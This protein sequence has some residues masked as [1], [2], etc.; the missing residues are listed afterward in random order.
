MGQLEL[1][2]DQ[3]QCGY[4]HKRQGSEHERHLQVTHLLLELEDAVAAP[5]ERRSGEST[6]A[7][8]LTVALGHRR[9]R[10]LLDGGVG[11]RGRYL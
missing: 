4:K 2:G 7:E 6:S 10:G 1:A 11:C 5:E 3:L 9:R 8:I